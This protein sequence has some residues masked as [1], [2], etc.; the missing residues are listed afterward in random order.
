MA[1]LDRLLAARSV[2]VVGASARPGSFGERLAIEA[3]R[4]PGVERVH[5]VNPAY[6]D[7]Q[8]R[9]CVPTLNDLAEPVDLVLMGV[10]DRAIADHLAAARESGAGGAVVYGS[11][12]GQAEAIRSAAGDLPVVGAGCMGFVNVSHG[13]RAL[14]YLERDHLVAGGIALITHSGS[15]FS[16]F[17]RSHRRLEY[18]IAVSSGQELITT[19]GDYLGWILDQPETR[20]IGLFLE[21]VR[22]SPLMRAGLARAAELGIPVVALTVGSSVTGRAMVT[23]HSGAIAGDDAAWEALFETYGVHRCH[24]VEE[25][26]DTLELFSIGRRLGSGQPGRAG[27]GIATVHDSGAQRVLMADLAPEEGVPFAELSDPTRTAI[28]HQLDEGLLVTNPLDVWGRGADTETLFGSCLVALAEEPNVDVVALAIDLV[29]EY[30]GDE[31]YPRAVLSTAA[32]T[33]KPVV[34]IS[35]VAASI[36]QVQAAHLRAA[37]IPVLEGARSGLRAIAHL[38]AHNPPTVEGSMASRHTAKLPKSLTPRRLPGWLGAAE[39]LALLGDY[40]IDV[41]ETIGATHLAGVLAAASSVGYPVVLKT[42][43]QGIEHRVAV[44]GVF[45]DVPD[46]IALSTA[47]AALSERIGPA[48]A[49]QPQLRASPATPEIALGILYDETVGHIAL[50]ALGGSNIEGLAQRVLALT[51]LDQAAAERLTHR[52]QRLTGVAAP[53]GLAQA[54]VGLSDL[55]TDLGDQLTAVDINP[56]LVVGDRLVAVDALIQ[57]SQSIHR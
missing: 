19:T 49:V 27:R 39:S 41:V 2:A 42:D 37:G 54:L 33:D 55:V 28:A 57:V 6:A 36:D 11:A 29:E 20:V 15:M 48:V 3:L 23:A 43:E 1:D 17:L 30:D 47:Y 40:G 52:W 44:D 53:A 26:V 4:S 24:D 22:N 38:R 12:V 45:L 21:T 50:A 56:L 16:A 25:F 14:G 9:P 5:L 35:H 10:P 31:S 34:V 7:V 46:D 32:A 18:S 8:G 13:L 51:P